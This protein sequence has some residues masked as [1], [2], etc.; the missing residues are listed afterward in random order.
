LRRAADATVARRES[1]TLYPRC[2]KA[3]SPRW[4][5]GAPVAAPRFFPDFRAALRALA[6]GYNSFSMRTPPPLRSRLAHDEVVV[7]DRRRI[8]SEGEPLAEAAPPA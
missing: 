7:R 8:C 1:R 5:F 3:V 4:L 2:S 6:V